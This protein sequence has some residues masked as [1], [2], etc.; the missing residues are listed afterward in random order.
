MRPTIRN[1]YL[2]LILIF[3][4]TYV[5]YYA[6]LATVILCTVIALAGVI[7]VKFY[8]YRRRT[9][10]NRVLFDMNV[11]NLDAMDGI[12]FEHFLTDLFHRLGYKSEATQASGDYGVDV[13]LIDKK[14]R[15]IAVQAKHYS[16]AVGLEAVQQA[17]TGI[18]YYKAAEGWVVTNSTFTK[19]A[20]NLAEA[21]HIRLIDGTQLRQLIAGA[22]GKSTTPAQP[23]AQQDS[24]PEPV[25]STATGPITTSSPLSSPPTQ[26]QQPS[27]SSFNN[28]QQTKPRL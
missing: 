12:S 27:P 2:L 17:H 8:L 4:M 14:G 24:Q 10:V 9:R 3:G 19:A 7:A 15:K 11:Q 28:D 22:D 23:S 5:L 20:H 18:T 1:F 13:L 6:G 26:Q 16:G 25:D 21:A